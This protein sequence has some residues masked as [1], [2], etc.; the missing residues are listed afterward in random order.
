[1]PEENPLLPAI[2]E[3]LGE[4]FALSEY[5]LIQRLKEQGLVA[6]DYSFSPL[7]LFQVHFCVFNAL[8]QI[9]AR[10]MDQGQALVISPLSIYVRPL[11]EEG[12]GAALAELEDQPLRTFYLDWNHYHQATEGSVEDLLRDFWRRYARLGVAGQEERQ[13]A[14]AELG[15]EDPVTPAEIKQRYRRLAMEHH[16]DRGGSAERLRMINDALAVLESKG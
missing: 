13:R 5:R 2:E 16:P 7:S 6:P 15:L 1:M 9:Q 11:D 12:R 3:L 14:L 8:Y 4:G 10:L